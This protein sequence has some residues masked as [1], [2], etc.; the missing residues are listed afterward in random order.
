MFVYKKKNNAG[1][2]IVRFFIR[3]KPHLI[4]I[5]DE[6]LYDMNNEDLV[7]SNPNPSHPSLW[8]PILEKAWSKIQFNY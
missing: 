5:D 3:G 6:V 8:G 4:T 2:Y 7:Y 1:I